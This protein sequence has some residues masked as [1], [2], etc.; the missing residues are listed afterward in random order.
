MEDN[1]T[2][3]YSSFSLENIRASVSMMTLTP[4]AVPRSA[5]V[6]RNTSM[7]PRKLFSSTCDDHEGPAASGSVS[8]IVD[9]SSER[10]P[11]WSTD[12]I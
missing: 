5:S 9:D 6:R 4:C 2:P 11:P 1:N 8:A 10:P 12:E 3:E 7:K